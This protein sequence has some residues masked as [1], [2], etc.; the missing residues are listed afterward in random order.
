MCYRTKDVLDIMCK[1]TGLSIKDL[2][3]DGGAVA[4]DFYA[5]FR[6]IFSV[7]MLSVQML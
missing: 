2:K 3:V 4:N 5:N 1:D 7:S 6:Q